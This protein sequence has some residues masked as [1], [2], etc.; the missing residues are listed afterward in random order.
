MNKHESNKRI[1]LSIDLSAKKIIRFLLIVIL[2]LQ[3]ISLFSKILY[4]FH[5]NSIPIKIAVQLFDVGKEG[6][7]PALY[8][9]ATLLVCAILLAVI[10]FTKRH[11]KDPYLFHWVGLSIIFSFLAWDEA[12]QVHEKLNKVTMPYQILDWLGLEAKGVFAFAWVIVGII[13][14]IVFSIIL[15]S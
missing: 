2:G 5:P 6:N 3:L 11:K 9:A 8:S 13:G 14:V 1:Y 15:I 12:V 10:S 4:K 7:I